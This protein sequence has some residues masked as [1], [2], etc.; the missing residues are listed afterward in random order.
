M[1]PS[2]SACTALYPN[3]N[4]SMSQFTNWGRNSDLAQLESG[5]ELH[6]RTQA[7]GG[8]HQFIG[9]AR[10]ASLSTAKPPVLAADV[11][12]DQSPKA[13]A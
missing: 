12:D 2:A 10:L 3:S 4:E 13:V 1:G 6:S 9:H 11:T 8:S 7:G 5:T